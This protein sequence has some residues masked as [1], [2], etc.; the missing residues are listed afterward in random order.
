M[1][2]IYE[3]LLNIQTELKAPK[4][5]R[6][7]F[8]NYNYRSCEDILEAL[9]P[10]LAKHKAALIINDDI[11]SKGEHQP[12]TYIESVWDSKAKQMKD[13]T[14]TTGDQ[15]YYIKATAKLINIEE[16]GE[17]IETTA[18]ARE[19][20]TK[21]GMDGSQLTGST[22]SYARKYALN[23]LFAIDDT[24]DSD[25]TNT[26]NKGQEKTDKPKKQ[27]S[28]QQ[29][30]GGEVKFYCSDCGVEVNQAVHS[31]STNKFSR[32]LCMNCQKKAK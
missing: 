17:V 12:I 8:G 2:N 31:Y 13:E 23:G 25:A 16:P 7:T 11:V 3:K 27:Q 18:Y 9:K 1:S 21:K 24:K 22:S 5:Q 32:C 29:S 30:Q 4:N 14:R 20:E 6:N 15:R 26:H 10:L 28:Q 19:D